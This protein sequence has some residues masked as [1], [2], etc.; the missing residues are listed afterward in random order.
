MDRTEYINENKQIFKTNLAKFIKDKGIKK[1]N[2]AKA[3]EVSSGTISDWLKGRSYP[4]FDKIRAIAEYLNIN[5]SDLT[6]ASSFSNRPSKE[7]QEF[8]DLFNGIADEK[9]ELVINLLRCLKEGRISEEKQKLLEL[10]DAIS[11]DKKELAI[12]LLNT[13]KQ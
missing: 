1:I 2:L 5:T 8:L 9:K 12:N 4:R 7:E 13:L 6:E 10:Y 11:D 3:V